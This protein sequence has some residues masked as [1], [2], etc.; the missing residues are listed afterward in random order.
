MRDEANKE[1]LTAGVY[2]SPLSQ[3]EPVEK[4]FLFQLQEASYSHDD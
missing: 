2:S 1:N 3:R 4:V